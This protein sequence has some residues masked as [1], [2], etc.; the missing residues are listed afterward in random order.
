[1]NCVYHD[2]AGQEGSEGLQPGVSTR[3]KLRKG[4][5]KYAFILIRIYEYSKKRRTGGIIVTV[6]RPGSCRRDQRLNFR[7]VCYTIRYFHYGA[8]HCYTLRG[9]P[10]MSV[11]HYAGI[12]RCICSWKHFHQIIWLHF[13]I[14]TSTTNKMT[15][16]LLHICRFGWGLY[17]RKLKSAINIRKLMPNKSTF[18]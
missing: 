3:Y 14:Q 8:S 7:N 2:Q 10:Y 9:V 12:F 17:L 18:Y 4:Q 16:F 5:G 13:R 11:T 15:G 6:V 1:M